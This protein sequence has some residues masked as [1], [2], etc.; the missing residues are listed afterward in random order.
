MYKINRTVACIIYYNE[1]DN[2]NLERCL[3]SI[4]NK[5]NYIVAVDGAYKEFPHDNFLSTDGSTELAKK[6]CSNVIIPNREWVDEIEKRN[7]YLKRLCYGDFVVIIDSDEEMIGGI[8][9]KELELGDI[10]DIPECFFYDIRLTRHDNVPPYNIYRAFKYF[11]TMGYQGTHNALWLK[12]NAFENEYLTN[13]IV[14]RRLI[15]GFHFEHY[16]DERSKQRVL[17]K[18]IYYRKLWEQE[19]DYRKKYGL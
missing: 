4:H 11:S 16:Q 14:P 7:S 10:K 9:K 2:D 5:F 13:S 6:Y 15:T 17:D 19:K 3:K 18:G 8:D 1:M 12:H